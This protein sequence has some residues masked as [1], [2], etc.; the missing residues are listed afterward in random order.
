MQLKT[1]IS[2]DLFSESTS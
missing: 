2:G 1:N